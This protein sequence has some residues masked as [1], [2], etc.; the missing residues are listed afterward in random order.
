[1][2]LA[3]CEMTQDSIRKCPARDITGHTAPSLHHGQYIAQANQY[4]GYSSTLL[5]DVV[6]SCLLIWPVYNNL[7]CHS[8]CLL[9]PCAAG[10]S[11]WTMQ[12]ISV[13]SALHSDYTQNNCTE[14]CMYM[15]AH[16]HVQACD[17]GSVSTMAVIP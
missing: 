5:S 15:H 3:V 4:L 7:L 11:Q 8:V 6:T 1:M 9:V 12:L 17:M 16:V 14:C 10:N 2:L 13:E